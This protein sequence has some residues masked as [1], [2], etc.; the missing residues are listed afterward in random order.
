MKHPKM[1]PTG[2]EGAGLRMERRRNAALKHGAAWGAG[3]VPCGALLGGEEALGEE[4]RR[5]L[6]DKTPGIGEDGALQGRG[7]SED[8]EL[9]EVSKETEGMRAL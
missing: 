1:N 3:R 5:P 8:S 7:L 6:E 9:S 2:A 4:R